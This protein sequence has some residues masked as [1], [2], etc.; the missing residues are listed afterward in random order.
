MSEPAFLLFAG[1]GGVG[2]TTLAA[3]T[4]LAFAERGHRTLL[5]S[6][7]P[8]HSAG[9]ALESSLGAD[10][11]QI[12]DNLW[13]V[14]LDPDAEAARYVDGVRRHV[15]DITPPGMTGEVDRQLAMARETPGV[16]EAAI[17][18]R[19]AVLTEG[20][21]SGW[22][23]IVVDTAPFGHTLRLLAMPDTM[24]VWLDAVIGRRRKLGA[25]EQMWRT[26][27]GDAPDTDRIL[28][29]LEARRERLRRL[30]SLLTDP[31]RA[32]VTLVA[33]PE[34]LS[35]LE[36]RRSA[37]TLRGSGIRPAALVVNRVAVEDGE[38]VAAFRAAFPELHLTELPLAPRTVRDRALL[39]YIGARLEGSP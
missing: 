20:L 23:R 21:G 26:V 7:D 35:L 17:L 30:R 13:A 19:L 29:V 8:A 15:A 14:E 12:V 37:E 1:K 25:L 22:D 28:A 10:P 32:A 39:H 16:V 31:A 36:T 4:A 38:H 27:R 24:R 3:A 33:I 11:T 34:R 9:D 2:K 6:T 18:E 5:I